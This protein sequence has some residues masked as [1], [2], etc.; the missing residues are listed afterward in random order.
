MHRG[1]ELEDV[2]CRL[3]NEKI[4]AAVRQPT[5]LVDKEPTTSPKR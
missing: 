4:T 1:L 5:D 2:L 3:D